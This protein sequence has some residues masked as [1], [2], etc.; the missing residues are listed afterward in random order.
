MK[1]VISAIL[2]MVMM[3]SLVVPAFAAEQVDQPDDGIV[4]TVLEDTATVRKVLVKTESVA[5]V[6]EYN[7]VCNIL[8]VNEVRDDV[9]V[10]SVEIDLN[11]VTEVANEPMVTSSSSDGHQK[12]DGDR[13]DY[14]YTFLNYEYDERLYDDYPGDAFWFLRHPKANPEERSVYEHPIDGSEYTDRINA[15]VDGVDKINSSEGVIGIVGV[16]AIGAWLVTKGIIPFP[17]LY[18][19]IKAVLAGIGFAGAESAARDLAHGMKD[20]DSAWQ[21]LFGAFD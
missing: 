19:G 16:G 8:T 10:N 17:E 14:E 15:Y 20:C 21:E 7:K 1:K 18:A 13:I 6:S 5:Y 2:V 12:E 3:F 9:L 11:K 4:T